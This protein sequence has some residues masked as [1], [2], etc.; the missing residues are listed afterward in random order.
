MIPFPI[1]HPERGIYAK[2]YRSIA[3]VD[4]AGRGPLAGPVVAAAV[5]LS[6]DCIIPGIADSK[7]LSAG[8]REALFSKIHEDAQAVGIGI[9]D[10][11]EIEKINILQASL[12]AMVFAVV[13]LGVLVDYLLVDGIHNIPNQIPQSVIKKGDSLSPSISAA[14]IIAKVTRDRIM[15]AYHRIYP[16]YNFAQNKGYGTKEHMLAIKRFGCR[17]IHRKTFKGVKE[18]L[19]G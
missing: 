15:V 16:E 17:E 7:K 12:K 5:I 10:Q 13:D 14:S 4:E 8:K 3:G 9:V 18:Y 11:R 19:G 6:E 1:T 2:G